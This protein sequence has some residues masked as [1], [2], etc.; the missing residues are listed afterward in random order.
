MKKLIR[1]FKES[2]S[3][4]VHKVSGEG[5][6][7]FSNYRHGSFLDIRCGRTGDGPLFREYHESSLQVSGKVI[8]Y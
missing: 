2:Y 5:A 6:A 1:Y 4:L 7:E 3:E 8:H